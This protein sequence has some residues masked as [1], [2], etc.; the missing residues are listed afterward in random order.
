MYTYYQAGT[1]ELNARQLCIAAH[2]P[3]CLPVDL[4]RE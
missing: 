4:L 3:S 1:G 2:R